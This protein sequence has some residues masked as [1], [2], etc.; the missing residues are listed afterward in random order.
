MT[1]REIEMN[2]SEAIAEL[3]CANLGY[4]ETELTVMPAKR[5]TLIFNAE[6]EPV[7]DESYVIFEADALDL[8]APDQAALDDFGHW[9]SEQEEE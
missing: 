7:G 9:C 6:F 2:R 3:L 8:G 1:A 5:L 4:T